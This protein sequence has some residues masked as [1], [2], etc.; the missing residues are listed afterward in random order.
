MVV[1]TDI[2]EHGTN[3]LHTNL[4]NGH[5]AEHNHTSEAIF[6]ACTAKVIVVSVCLSVTTLS[7]TKS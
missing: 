4:W 5:D 3:Y 1:C 6:N 7:A 2:L